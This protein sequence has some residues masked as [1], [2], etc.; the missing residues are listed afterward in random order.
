LG[1]TDPLTPRRKPCKPWPEL[2][3]ISHQEG[4]VRMP[5]W[6]DIREL[7][8]SRYQLDDDEKEWFSLIFEYDSGRTQKIFVRKIAVLGVDW[9]EFRSAVCKES[10]MEHRVALRKNVELGLGALALDADGDY[11]LIYAAPLPTMDLEELDLPL[12]A[13]AATADQLELEYSGGKDEF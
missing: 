10:E 4:V 13:I 6:D 8:R 9:L 11:V 2:E 7:V 1:P 3:A 12:H 5:T